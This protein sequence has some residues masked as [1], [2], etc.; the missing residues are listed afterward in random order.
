MLLPKLSSK[1]QKKVLKYAN[2]YRVFVSFA[3]AARL[4]KLGATRS[5]RGR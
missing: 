1:A 4:N 2:A 5:F 3:K